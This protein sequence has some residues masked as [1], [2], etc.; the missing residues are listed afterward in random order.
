[1]D[2]EQP[3]TFAIFDVFTVVPAKLLVPQGSGVALVHKSFAGAKGVK[4]EVHEMVVVQQFV[5]VPQLIFV[6]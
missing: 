1:L 3:E 5:A 2:I 4:Q 6:L